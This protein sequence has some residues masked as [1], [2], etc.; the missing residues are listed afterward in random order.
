M[1]TVS[2]ERRTSSSK[3][4][5]ANIKAL[6]QAR[7]DRLNLIWF[8]FCLFEICILGSY[9]IDFSFKKN[10]WSPDWSPW[11]SMTPFAPLHVLIRIMLRVRAFFHK[12]VRVCHVYCNFKIGFTCRITVIFGTLKG[13]S[14]LI[15][16]LAS[17]ICF[18]YRN[19]FQ[20]G[21][22]AFSKIVDAFLSKSSKFHLVRIIR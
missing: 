17:N 15:N 4:L 13:G 5:W 12:T 9:W 3:V 7:H 20:N 22:D 16:T 10:D 19:R 6:S 1:G 11:A 14:L 21:V 18:G 8:I 2:I